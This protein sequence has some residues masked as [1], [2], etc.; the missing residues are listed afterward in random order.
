VPPL[1]LGAALR[2]LRDGPVRLTTLGYLGH[3]WEL[4]ALWAWLPAFF[5]ASRHA[6][7]G[8]LLTGAVAFAAIG[9]AGLLGAVAAG[10]LADRFGRTA[11]TSGAMVV[12]AACC[13]ASPVAYAAR[14]AAL[15]GILMVW[16]ASVIADSAQFSA[17]VTEL[18][19]PRYAGS[20]LTLQ[21]ALGFALTILSIRLVPRGGR[22]RRLA[23]RPPRARRRPAERH[24]RHAPASGLARLPTSR[25]RTPMTGLRLPARAGGSG[26]AAR[27]GAWRRRG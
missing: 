22:R 12:S 20:A 1:D 2:A 14:T 9:V 19:E 8:R 27:L 21:L 25:G 5:V 6:A 3:M 18:A 10:H 16:G 11:T 7:P 4:Y 13:L 15:A 24:R 23:L 17:A 26:P